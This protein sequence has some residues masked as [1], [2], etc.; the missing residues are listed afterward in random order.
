MRQLYTSLKTNVFFT[1]T[2]GTGATGVLKY[3]ALLT[4]SGTSD[5]VATVLN[6][7]DSDYLGDIVWTR[8]SAGYYNGTLLGVFIE[9]KT[10]L[11]TWHILNMGADAGG[12]PGELVIYSANYYRESDDVISIDVIKSN[13]GDSLPSSAYQNVDNAAF[14]NIKVEI[15][16]YP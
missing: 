7:S 13:G 5:P 12:S 6:G 8:G 14:Q 4:Q 2:G 9:N 16:V 10:L 11:P 15:T 3:V 1:S